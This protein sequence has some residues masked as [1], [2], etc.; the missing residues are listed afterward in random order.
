MAKKG[1]STNPGKTK[2]TKVRT[3]KRGVTGGTVNQWW[4]PG[5][6]GNPSGRPKLSPEL[7]ALKDASL[8]RAIEIMH[9]ILHDPAY[10]KK[11]KPSDLKAFIAEACDRCGLPKV[12][13]AELSGPNG[14]PFMAGIADLSQVDQKTLEKLANG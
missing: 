5:Q 11:M 8:Q 2:E 3:S 1:S 9:G 6:S 13:K 4:K 10:L 7:K 12:T 14:K